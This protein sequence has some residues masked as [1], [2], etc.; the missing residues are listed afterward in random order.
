MITDL[1]TLIS[2]GI[3]AGLLFL[4][5]LCFLFLSMPDNPS[6]R[7][8]R[9]ARR[10]MA[11]AYLFFALINAAEYFSQPEEANIQL[12]Q[13]ITLVIACSQAFLF[14]FTLI[15]LINI[16]FVTGRRI[17]FES[18]PVISLTMAAFVIYFAFPETVFRI[19]YYLFIAGY[20]VLLVRYV[21]MFVKNWRYY[22]R[23]MDNYFADLEAQR[24]RWVSLSFYAA[25]IIGIM[26][27]LSAIFTSLVGAFIF[28][29]IVVIF[30]TYFAIRFINYAYQFQTIEPAF[31]DELTLD[32]AGYLDDDQEDEA[33][34][35][36]HDNLEKRIEQWIEDKRFAEKGI[37]LNTLALELGTNRSYLSKYFNTDM[38][39]TFRDWLNLLRIEEAQRLLVQYPEAS[40]AKIAS[41]VGFSDKS[42]FRRHFINLTGVSPQDWRSQAQFKEE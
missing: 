32:E 34:A 27:L 9:L 33:D 15:T 3:L 18:I 26:A 4:S 36:A 38:G 2:I 13:L 41:Q 25:L 8:Y 6:L 39:K 20:I 30:Y 5:A 11:C 10:V 28:S 35:A 17:L 1:Y 23:Q 21:G 42:N 16:R 12:V 37:I 24:L 19:F 29:C 7:N 22:H 14:T 31:D 40:I